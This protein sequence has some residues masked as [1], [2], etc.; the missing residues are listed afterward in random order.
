MPVPAPALT[1]SC[2]HTLV[3]LHC[4]VPNRE[5]VVRQKLGISE[6]ALAQRINRLLHEEQQQVRKYRGRPTFLGQHQ[7]C[8]GD[9]YLMDWRRNF[10]LDLVDLEALGRELGAL[11]DHERLA[12]EP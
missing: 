5:H 12:E 2:A 1:R 8:P 7:L 10:V 4:G 9:W 11:R 6:R 3:R